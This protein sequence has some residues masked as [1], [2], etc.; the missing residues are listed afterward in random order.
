[1]TAGGGEAFEY[2]GYLLK[3]KGKPMIIEKANVTDAAAILALQRLAYQSEA[4]L[5]ADFTI[6]PLTQTL[7]ELTAEFAG[8][9]VLKAMKHGKIIGSVQ[10]HQVGFTCQIGRLMVEPARQGQGIGTELLRAIEASFP[11]IDRYELFTGHKSLANIR[12]YERMGY[13]VFRTEPVSYG[14]SLVF[15]EKRVGLGTA[16]WRMLRDGGR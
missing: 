8:R 7:G 16:T 1:M 15:M 3:K 11:G 13:E 2:A 6:P 5:Y 4:A 12:L 14:L 9:T 10:G